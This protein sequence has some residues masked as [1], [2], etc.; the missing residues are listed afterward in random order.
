MALQNTVS[1]R[2]ALRQELIQF[3]D[4]RNDVDGL[5]GKT[6]ANGF[7][8]RLLLLF[9]RLRVNRLAARDWENRR[10][11]RPKLPAGQIVRPKLVC[12]RSEPY[13]HVDQ[14]SI[15]RWI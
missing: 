4:L 15:K 9:F 12:T 8:I 14:K 2:R 6:F 13:R 5:L 11:S 1:V 7:D 3:P 10:R